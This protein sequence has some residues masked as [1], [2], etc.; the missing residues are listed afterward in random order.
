MATIRQN[1]RGGARLGAGRP[2]LGSI[3]KLSIRLPEEQ[4]EEIDQ[5]CSSGQR[6]Q[7][8]VIAELVHQSLT[9]SKG[10]AIQT[11]REDPEAKLNRFKDRYENIVE[12]SRTSDERKAQLLALLMTEME[13]AFKIPLMNNESYNKANPEIINLYRTISAARSTLF[14]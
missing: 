5:A 4:W 11:V 6:S 2:K 13:K 8:E 14:D 12:W 3:R 9:S 7:A 10:D 1:I